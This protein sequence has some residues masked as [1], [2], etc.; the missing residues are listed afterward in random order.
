MSSRAYCFMDY[1]TF[2]N[3]MLLFGCAAIYQVGIGQASRSAVWPHPKTASLQAGS[4]T[5]SCR[6]APSSVLRLIGHSV[7]LACSSLRGVEWF[8]V[9]LCM[10]KYEF[11]WCWVIYG[12]LV[13]AKVWR[14]RLLNVRGKWVILERRTETCKMLIQFSCWSVTGVTQYG[15]VCWIEK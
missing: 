7:R 11:A 2:T 15:L 6:S 8:M 10:R 9:L 13:Y 5:R 14:F 1:G 4:S 3:R 12:T